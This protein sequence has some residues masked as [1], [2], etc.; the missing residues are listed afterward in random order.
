MW[1]YF[2]FL[3]EALVAIERIGEFIR[4]VSLDPLPAKYGSIE[5]RPEDQTASRSRAC[6]SLN[7]K[8]KRRAAAIGGR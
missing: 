4:S 3:P 2:S 7:Q 5:S 1:D 6:Q 8:M